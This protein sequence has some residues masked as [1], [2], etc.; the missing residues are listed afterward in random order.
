MIKLYQFAP[1]WGLPNPSSFCFKVETYLRMANLPYEIVLGDLTK[2]PKGKLPYIED[3]GKVIAD[4]NFILDYLKSTY[5]NPLDAHLTQSE[6]AIALAMKRLIEENLYW[7]IVYSRWVEPENWEITKRTFFGEFPPVLR[8]LIPVLA[9]KSMFKSLNGHGIGKHD[10]AEVYQIGIAD[11]TALS[12]FLADKPFFM[13][14]RPTSLDAVA[15][16]TLANILQTPIKSPLQD[17]ARTFDNFSR[18]CD[19]MKQE[20]YSG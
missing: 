4:S 17:A 9:R 6:T 16:G 10:A 20:F 8:S 13:G 5:G 2:A 14:E 19:R 7:G 12:H 15:Y 11:L 3:N 18:Y 1:A